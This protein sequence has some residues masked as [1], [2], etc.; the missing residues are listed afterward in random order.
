MNHCVALSLLQIP[1]AGKL[2]GCRNASAAR[3]PLTGHWISA[4]MGFLKAKR[5]T[6]LYGGKDV[7]KTTFSFPTADFL[8]ARASDGHIHVAPHDLPVD[9]QSIHGRGTN[10]PEFPIDRYRLPR[11]TAPDAMVNVSRGEPIVLL[12]I[13][14]EKQC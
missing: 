1:A 4:S 5:E 10:R 8:N 14:T 9:A 7:Y 11:D 2:G 13:R 6:R 12:K 3:S